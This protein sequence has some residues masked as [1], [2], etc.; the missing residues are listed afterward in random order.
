MNNQQLSLEQGSR[1][2][3]CHTCK[4]TIPKKEW[5]LATY[6]KS[7]YNWWPIRENSC[8]I[9]LEHTVK[10]IKHFIYRNGGMKNRRNANITERLIQKL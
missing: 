8:I 1:K 5:H 10:V 3:T 9:C 4:C 6:N 7:Q 2:R